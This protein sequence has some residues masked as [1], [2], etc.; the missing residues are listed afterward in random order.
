VRR[1]SVAL[2]VVALA[3]IAGSAAAQQCGQAVLDDWYDDGS[4]DG[5]WSCNCMLDALASLPEDGR[6]RFFAA[7]EATERQ[8]RARCAVGKDVGAPASEASARKL[9][10][11]AGEGTYYATDEQPAGDMPDEPIV[12]LALPS[13]AGRAADD[14]VDDFVPWQSVIIGMV[15]GGLL[16]LIGAAAVRQRG[17]RP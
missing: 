6:Q 13:R 1:I 9:T 12:T 2:A 17:L 5:H 7:Q 10:E 11:A 16:V 14:G 3:L 8:L 4:F 15:T